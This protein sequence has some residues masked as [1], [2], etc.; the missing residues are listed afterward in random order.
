MPD[1]GAI[2]DLGLVDD[3]SLEGDALLLIYADEGTF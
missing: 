1:W 3:G 2:P